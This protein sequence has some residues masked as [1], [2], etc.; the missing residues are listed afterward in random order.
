MPPK[1]CERWTSRA[2]RSASAPCSAPSGSTTIAQRSQARLNSTKP[3][4][5]AR[6][7]SR[8]WP[9]AS[10][11]ASAVRGVRAPNRVVTW[12]R[13]ISPDGPGVFDGG[14][15]AQGPGVAEALAGDLDRD[16]LLPGQ[17][18][19]AG[20]GPRG[21]P[22]PLRVPARQ[23]PRLRHLQRAAQALQGEDGVG[24]GVVGEPVEVDGAQLGQHRRCSLD[25][26]GEAFGHPLPPCSQYR[27]AGD[28]DVGPETGEH[29]HHSEH[30][31]VCQPGSKVSVGRIG[32]WRP[33]DRSGDRSPAA[34]AG[35][36]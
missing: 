29:P 31:F 34:V 15:G 14:Q 36:R 21:L 32:R 24:Q 23:H 1:L 16:P 28:R 19:R 12:A 6:S 18:R 30:T 20:L 26:L 13:S 17:P 35:R 25:H 9:S 22:A 7:R 2:A 4:S 11:K 10:S 3:C 5:R 27:V 33:Q 8:W